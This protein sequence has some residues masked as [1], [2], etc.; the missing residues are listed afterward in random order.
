V[1]LL[2][3]SAL[4]V[5][6]AAPAGRALDTAPEVRLF[7]QAASADEK[8]AREA[9]DRIAAGW[10]DGYAAMLLDLARFMRGPRRMGPAR[11]PWPERGPEDDEADRERA[12]PARGGLPESDVAA[13]ARGSPA[14][15]R[16]ISFL[17]KQ[18]GQRFGDD[19]RKWRLWIWSRPYEP[20][21]DYAFFKAAVYS[22]ID[23]GFASFFRPGDTALIRL[24]EVDWGGVK[25]NGIPPL[26][27]P[28]HVPA[29]EAEYLRD[30]NVVFGVALGGEARAYPKRI[31]AWHEMA[32]DRLGGVELTIVYCTL[33]GTVVPYGSEV[34]GQRR[35]FGT[36]GLLYRSNKLM[37]DHET[38]S[39][40]STA[41]GRPV[42]GPL[43]GKGLELQAYPVVTTTWKEWV[44][45][46]PETTVLSRDTGFERD[47]SEGA[48]YRD[49]FATDQLMFEVP[50]TDSRL[51]NKAEV[52]TLLLRPPASGPDAPRRALALAVEFLRKNPVHHLSFAGHDL[53]VFTSPGGANRVY[54]AGGLRFVR[55]LPGD[56]AQDQ[57]GGTWRIA[58]DAL[59]GLGGQG[60]ARPR[61]PARR[62]FWFG[63]Y[64]QFP[65]TELVR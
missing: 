49:Y 48:A 41:E 44:A 24:D 56:L 60:E 30:G 16:L 7:F 35:R 65:E 25:V 3:A 39:L 64:A 17:Q 1:R 40:W 20:H 55:L 59:V 12:G 29:K 51:K 22:N 15:A 8:Q 19:L 47:Y 37:F 10:K 4:A 26:D 63:W 21:P 50:K 34:S 9:L 46:H 38:M 14:R 32:L 36:S 5:A 42:I 2:A 13:S 11:E 57:D 31:L 62:A 45:A 28:K 52:L 6:L 61:V 54:A 53:V 27:H 23:P 33:C 43:A 18:T 58:E